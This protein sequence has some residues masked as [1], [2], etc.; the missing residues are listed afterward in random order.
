MGG[1]RG[2][3]I[4]FRH[5]QFAPA[6]E[7]ERGLNRALRQAGFFRERTQ[8]SRN[9]FPFRARRLSVKMKINEIRRRLAIVPDDVAHQDIEDVI[10]DRNGSAK[11]RHEGK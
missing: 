10:V 3:V 2:G 8:T 1:N 5:D 9:R 6:Q 4:A 7:I 11:T